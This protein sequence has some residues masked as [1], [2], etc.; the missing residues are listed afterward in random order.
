[1]PAIFLSRFLPIAHSL[2]P[3]IVGGAGM[4]YRR[5]FVWTLPA[6]IVWA[7]AY[8]SVGWAAGGTYRELADQLHGAGYILVAA[9]A[10]FVVL[11]WVGTRIISRSGA[12]HLSDEPPEND[13]RPL[14][15]DA[16][17]ARVIREDRRQVLS[18]GLDAHRQVPRIAIGVVHERV[19]HERVESA[20]RQLD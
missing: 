4:P 12:R 2:V 13:W 8:A 16:S 3:L 1:G 14:A 7:T 20:D 10:V 11:V 9:I 18:R 6:C 19:G 17:G 5:F 15:A